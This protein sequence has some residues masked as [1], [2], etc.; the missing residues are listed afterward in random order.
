M[1]DLPIGPA[2]GRDNGYMDKTA[3]QS[4]PPASCCWPCL[5]SF[6]LRCSTAAVA[7]IALF[8]LSGKLLESPLLASGV[9]LSVPMAP[10]TAVSFLLLA[11]ALSPDLPFGRQR[12]LRLGLLLPVFLFSIHSAVKYAAAASTA[13]DIPVAWAQLWIM[14]P[15]TAGLFLLLGASAA[16]RIVRDPERSCYIS[17]WGAALAAALSAVILLGYL[18]GVPFF[19]GGSIIPVAATTAVCFLLLSVSLLIETGRGL[20][21]WSLFEGDSPTAWM[22]RCFVPL[23]TGTFLAASVLDE[24]LDLSGRPLLDAALMFTGALCVTWLV[25]R[26]S[27][28]VGAG[29]ESAE[30]RLRDS[31]EQ[32][33]ALIE[34]GPESVLV[35]EG[36]KLVY[37]N[38]AAVRLFG[39]QGREALLGKEFTAFVAPEYH[40]AVRECIR[41]LEEAG[42]AAPL[43]ELE[44]LRQDGGRI[45]VETAAVVIRYAGKDSVLVFVRNIA[46]RKQAEEDRLKAEAEHG[47]MQEQFL[48]SQKMGAVGRLAGGVAH[49]FNNLL[50]AITGYAG[51]LLRGLPPGDPGREDA[52]EILTAAERAAGLTKQLLAFSRKQ[53]LVPQVLD[54]NAGVIGMANML[55]RIIG[56]DIKLETRLCDPSC[57]VKVDSGQLGQVLLN[58]AVN[59]RDAMPK[60]GT[61]KLE[62][63]SITPGA[64]FSRKHPDLPPGEL[65]Y[66]SVKDTGCGMTGEVRAHL[67]EPFF[68]TKDLGKGTGL[69]LA[70]VYGIIKQSGGEIEVESSPGLGTDFRIYLP[71]AKPGE[72]AEQAGGEVVLTGSETVL[73]VDDEETLLRLGARILT[74]SGYKVLTAASGRLALELMEKRGEPVDLLVTDVVMHGMSG[75][76]L[77]KELAAR[78]LVGRTLYVSGY[79]DEAIAKHGVLEPGLAFLYKPF[80]PEV[81]LRKMREV[82]GGPPDKAK[83]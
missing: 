38:N 11:A 44:Y 30:L 22:M 34:G 21:P 79:T 19:Y 72:A 59:A 26:L 23:T 16:A 40:A 61:L 48:Q 31:E 76:E 49:D 45:P 37:L 74:G 50:T 35:L 58:L 4:G 9:S 73:L 63:G 12:R 20:W 5:R 46:A 29:I 78:K 36:G 1:R 71:P 68:T 54:L 6:Q 83:P 8:A 47:K 77:A 55:K 39:A 13:T 32:F 14:S 3:I 10:S 69:G 56:D 52:Q 25:T 67:F 51:F 64:E 43:L 57:H 70:T 24:R 42:G 18:Y 28:R 80:A 82:L 2:R 33:R 60:G 15:L 53:I 17:A 75:R 62:S 7:V 41:R 66:L 27:A 81:L 65:V